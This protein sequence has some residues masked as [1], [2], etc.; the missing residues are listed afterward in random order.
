M[1]NKNGRNIVVSVHVIKTY[2]GAEIE[3]Q[4]FLNSE[5]DRG[6]WSASR[7][8]RLTT[9]ERAFATYC[10]AGCMFPRNHP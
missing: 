3:L 7:P 5:L 1:S 6:E 8:R 10:I 4:S 2:L 9:E